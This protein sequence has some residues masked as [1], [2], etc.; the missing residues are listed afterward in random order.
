MNSKLESKYL[1]LDIHLIQIKNARVHS[2][3]DISGV[4]TIEIDLGDGII[5]LVME[6]TPMDIDSTDYYKEYRVEEIELEG[7]IYID[8]YDGIIAYPEFIVELEEYI[9]NHIGELTNGNK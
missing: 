8:N 3:S 6:V 9:I 5:P 2:R 4:N 1:D 7:Y